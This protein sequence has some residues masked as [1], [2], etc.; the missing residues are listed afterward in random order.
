MRQRER[1]DGFPFTLRIVR[2][3]PEIEFRSPVTFLVGENGTGKSTLLEAIAAAVN[4][5]AIGSAS[6]QDDP[7]LAGARRL[8]DILRVARGP[9]P[10]ASFFFRAEDTFGFQKKVAADM[11]E[12]KGYEEGFRADLEGYGR[13][14]AVGAVRGQRRALEGRYGKDPDAFSHGEV[15]LGIL[16]SR[17]VPNGL[18]FMDEPET[19]LSPTR[20][21]SLISILKDRVARGCQFLI[22]TH[23]PIL[24]AFPDADI[25]SLQDGT[26]RRVGY[27][28]VEHVVVTRSFLRN[29]DR[30]LK[31]L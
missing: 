7:S 12:L 27:D 4:A 24:M 23:S 15:F 2:R 6:M 28:E 16:Q 8:A 3:M 18:Y 10:K 31:K 30:Y 5:V 20:V 19:P 26:I 17:L 13:Q 25:L 29:P 22:A 1:L 14:L 11:A 21:L 9:R